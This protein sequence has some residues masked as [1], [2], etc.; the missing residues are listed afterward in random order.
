MSTALPTRAPLLLESLSN[1]DLLASY[2]Q[3]KD[4]EA[5]ILALWERLTGKNDPR[6]ILSQLKKKSKYI[7]PHGSNPDWI[8]RGSFTR[9]YYRFKK[10]VCNYKGRID[11][12]A[13]EH[14]IRWVVYCSVID[15]YRFEN[16]PNAGKFGQLGDL[17][18]DIDD[19]GQVIKGGTKDIEIENETDQDRQEDEERLLENEGGNGGHNGDAE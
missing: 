6:S 13:F 2:C 14:F 16:G 3:R 19:T 8:F 15:E 10:Y 9:A 7:F 4:E 1:E 12:P 5:A 11:T 18:L 17:G